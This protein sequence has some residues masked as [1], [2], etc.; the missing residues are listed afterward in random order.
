MALVL[1]V[2]F[3]HQHGD[4]L[5]FNA[6]VPGALCEERRLNVEIRLH[7]EEVERR[8]A[9]LDRHRNHLEQMIDERTRRL[10]MAKEAAEVANVAKSSFWPT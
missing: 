3:V 8:E 10:K 6:A 1:L 2:Y 7:L 9:E 5:V 4:E